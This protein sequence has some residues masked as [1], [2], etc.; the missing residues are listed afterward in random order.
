MLRCWISAIDGLWFDDE[1]VDMQTDVHNSVM[2]PLIYR[3]ARLWARGNILSFL[4]L[5]M[6][7][8][9]ATRNVGF[10]DWTLYEIT[11][12]NKLKE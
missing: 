5:S 9:F 6:S 3:D 7:F 4:T 2:K 11:S 12:R 8:P 1:E 10:G